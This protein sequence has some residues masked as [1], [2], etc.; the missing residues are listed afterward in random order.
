MD[1]RRE[2]RYQQ[3]LLGLYPAGPVSGPLGR[4]QYQQA[5]RLRDDL[6]DGRRREEVQGRQLAANDGAAV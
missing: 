4:P 6:A 1:R 3:G 5:Y 2:A